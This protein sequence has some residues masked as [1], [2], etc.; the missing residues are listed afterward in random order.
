LIKLSIHDYNH[1]R[2]HAGINYQIPAQLYDA[3]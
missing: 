2:L 3:A 1:C